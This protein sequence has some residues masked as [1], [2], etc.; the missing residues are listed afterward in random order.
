[1][2]DVCFEPQICRVTRVPKG[3]KAIGTHY[4]LVHLAL[5]LSLIWDPKDETFLLTAKEIIFSIIFVC[6]M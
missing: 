5:F 1:M 2:A 4:K 3:Q 6:G